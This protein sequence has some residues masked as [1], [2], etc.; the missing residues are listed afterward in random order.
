VVVG[1]A[2]MGGC[3]MLWWFDVATVTD[4]LVHWLRIPTR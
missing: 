4:G 3:C 2:G 1:A